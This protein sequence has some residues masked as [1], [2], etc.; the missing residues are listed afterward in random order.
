LLPG[1]QVLGAPGALQRLGDLVLTMLAMRVAQLGQDYGS[2]FAREDGLEDGHAGHTR[3]ITDDLGELEVHLLQGLLH[4]L[5]MLG[6][7]GE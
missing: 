2:A 3:D 4:G 1:Q 6:G 7:R 5:N